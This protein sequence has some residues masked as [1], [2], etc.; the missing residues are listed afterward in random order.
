MTGEI[1]E[2]ESILKK[3]GAFFKKNRK[4]LIIISV[5]IVLAVALLLFFKLK[6]GDKKTATLNKGVVTRGDVTKMIEGT[7]TIEAIDQYEVTSVGIRGEI[8]QCTFEEGDE[9]KKDQVLYVIDSSDMQSSIDRAKLSLERAQTSYDDAVEKYNKANED[10]TVKA[11]ASGVIT[12]LNVT[13][14]S[15][16]NNGMNVA[17]IKDNS[18]MLLTLAFNDG[19]AELLRVGETAEVSLENSYTTI[20]GTV[21]HIG[22][23][24]T[25]NDY[26]AL[27][28]MVEITVDNPGSIKDGDK[29]TAIVGDIACNSEG[30]FKSNQEKT[31]TANLSGDVYG[32][33]YKVGD[34]ITEGATLFRIDYE[35]SDLNVKNAKN[36]LQDAKENLNN[37][38]KDMED[39]SIKAPID[40][41]IV[42]K[43]YKAGEK[44]DNSAS[45]N[46]PLA[47]IS[48]LSILTFDINID[49][50]DIA[51]IKVGQDV[52]ITA[53]AFA[54]ERFSGVV[55]KISVVG[56]SSQGVTTYPVTIVVNSENKDMLIPGMNVSANIVIEKSE[57]VLR[58]PVSALRRGNVVIAKT[59]SDGV[60][61][62]FGGMGQRPNVQQN[63]EGA[64]A[65]KEMPSGEGI[66]TSDGNKK[67]P[68]GENAPKGE[69]TQ[70]MPKTDDSKKDS[71]NASLGENK[72]NKKSKESA[73]NKT[74][75]MPSM[76]AK[77][78]PFLRNL[79]IPDGYKA[80]FVEVGL[81]DD[82]FVEIKAGLNE[83]DEVIL[84]D[85]TTATSGFG[86]MGGNR[87]PMGGGMMGGN[88]MPSGGMGANRSMGGNRNMGR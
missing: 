78:N 48:D 12:A 52:S 47:I 72:E 1:K 18:K 56:T 64:N 11:T 62:S 7:G 38:Y 37:L 15:K 84:P 54:N 34:Y 88:R 53:D 68:A 73:Q 80:I 82:N 63:K 86:M 31:V 85:A 58:I 71:S 25:I 24:A 5:I 45:G 74:G 28:K 76:D 70:S 30:T 4:K 57:N 77:D 66:K 13:E 43:N 60:T 16:V 40:G 21:T 36:S 67:M 22:T 59:D 69:K 35:N 9:V 83:G 8:L 75:Q 41:K 29:A 23:G 44:I 27:I 87:M 81:T 50:L 10:M 3:T 14:D 61:P 51:N 20:Y 6:G 65:N 55:D 26:G 19:E 46:S 2:K 39:Y 33:S 49:E 79:E 32:L 17:T 42:Q